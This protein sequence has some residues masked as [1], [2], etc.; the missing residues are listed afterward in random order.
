MQIM[1][2][3]FFLFIGISAEYVGNITLL[4]DK[5]VFTGLNCLSQSCN[6]NMDPLHLTVKLCHS[7]NCTNQTRIY[8]SRQAFFEYYR[9]HNP[10]LALILTNNKTVINSSLPI[11]ALPEKHSKSLLSNSAQELVIQYS[12]DCKC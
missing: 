11:F 1:L 2:A 8:S 9:E 4:P 7:S 3:T 10:L 12:F 5:K 6:R